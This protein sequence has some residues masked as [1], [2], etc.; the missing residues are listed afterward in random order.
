MCVFGNVRLRAPLGN[1]REHVIGI[2]CAVPRDVTGGSAHD[3]GAIGTL[4]EPLTTT[5]AAPVWCCQVA[6]VDVAAGTRTQKR[7]QALAETSACGD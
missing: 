2:G 4:A 1:D 7:P 3:I 6:V 5:D